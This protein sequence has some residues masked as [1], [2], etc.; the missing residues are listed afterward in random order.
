MRMTCPHSLVCPLHW[1]RSRHLRGCEGRGRTRTRMA[2][3]MTRT[4][5]SNGRHSV[6][7][8]PPSPPHC[9]HLCQG[10]AGL[11]FL[12]PAEPSAIHPHRHRPRKGGPGAGWGAPGQRRRGTHVGP[13]EQLQ[14]DQLQL[15]LTLKSPA[16]SPFASAPKTDAISSNQHSK[17]FES[18]PRR[19][20]RRCRRFSCCGRNSAISQRAKHGATPTPSKRTRQSSGRNP[21]TPALTA[22]RPTLA[23]RGNGPS[24]GQRMHHV[25]RLHDGTFPTAA[26]SS[27]DAP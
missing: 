22:A 4:P 25:V 26:C 15:G 10:H 3:A 5:P 21:C 7:L 6:W 1:G 16:F 24:V 9:H 19:F 27:V 11:R 17:L 20:W 14:A 23:T 18:A 8:F 2:G 12:A 13:Q